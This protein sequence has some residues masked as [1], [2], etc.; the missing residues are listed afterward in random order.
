[1][2]C[3]RSVLPFHLLHKR[4]AE[5]GGS[6]RASL[7]SQTRFIAFG[8]PVPARQRTSFNRR[9]RGGP[10]GKEN[11][12]PSARRGAGTRRKTVEPLRTPRPRRKSSIINHKSSIKR[13]L[14]SVPVPAGRAR[15]GVAG[16]PGQVVQRATCHLLDPAGIQARRKLRH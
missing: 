5:A 4:C 7:G 3:A 9:G 10:Q 11:Q 12:E 8:V 6:R 16:L 2:F 1:M 13:Q 14:A 15:S